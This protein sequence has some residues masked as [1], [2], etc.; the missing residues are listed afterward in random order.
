MSAV[1]REKLT[2]YLEPCPESWKQSGDHR[3]REAYHEGK[4]SADTAREL[5]ALIDTLSPRRVRVVE[6]VCIGNTPCTTRVKTGTNLKTGTPVKVLIEEVD[7][8]E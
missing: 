5:L 6:G 7:D 8:G 1:V 2:G 3:D 4:G